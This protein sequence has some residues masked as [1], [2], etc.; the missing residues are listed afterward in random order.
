MAVNVRGVW[1][2]L[3]Y[4][5]PVMQE[6]GGGSIVITSSTAGIRGRTSTSAYTTSK[7]AVIGLMRS[8]ALECAP[9]NIRVNTV[10]PAPIETRMMRSLEQQRAEHAT[11][12]AK[13][14]TPDRSRRPGRPA[15][16]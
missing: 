6:R 3:K 16:R 13:G 7:H 1:L 5:I 2:G 15:S 11:D 8:A 12:R 9:L 14:S 10:N 4:V